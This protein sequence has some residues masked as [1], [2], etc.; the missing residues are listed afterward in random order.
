MPVMPKPT[1]LPLPVE[2]EPVQLPL[3]VELEPVQPVAIA[4][5]RAARLYLRQ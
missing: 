3:P 5:A 2:L 1:Q 4:I